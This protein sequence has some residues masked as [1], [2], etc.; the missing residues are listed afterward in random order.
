MRIATNIIVSEECDV[1]TTKRFHA[2]EFRRVQ[3]SSNF[4]GAVAFWRAIER[5]A[6]PEPQTRFHAMGVLRA[7][8]ESQ[9][10]DCGGVA[11]TPQYAEAFRYC[12][13]RAAVRAP[14]ALAKESER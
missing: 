11:L 7:L 14:G 6:D 4:F 2:E 12:G 1:N 9:F 5:L 3:R 8:A 13:L 10:Q